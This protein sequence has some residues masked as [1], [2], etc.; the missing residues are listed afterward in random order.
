MPMPNHI[1]RD[2]FITTSAVAKT[3]FEDQS[4]VNTREEFLARELLGDTGGGAVYAYFT[5]RGNVLYVGQTGRTVKARLHDQT[6]PHK[7]KSW[8]ENWD[9]MRFVQTKCD[10]DR[11]FLEAL[12]IAIYEPS[13][14][15]KPK[16]KPICELFKD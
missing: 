2:S 6:S 14:N 7:K 10:V 9:Y 3:W 13:E 16:A 5:D 4:E 11:Y 15:E 12:L 8:W 1:L